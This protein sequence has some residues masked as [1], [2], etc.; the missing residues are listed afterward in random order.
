[1]NREVVEQ[2]LRLEGAAVTLA[3]DGAAA[4]E[5]LRRDPQ[6]YGLVLMDVQM[7]VMD[8]LTAARR[9]RCELGLNDLPLIAL[10]AGALPHER[11]AALAAGMNDVLTKP[12]RLEALVAMM[13]RYGKPRGQ[14][15]PQAEAFP[16]IPGIDREQATDILCGNRPLF[17]R[18]LGLFLA[19][20]DGL[21]RRVREALAQGHREKAALGLHKLKGNSGSLGA[22]AIMALAGSLEE[23]V[24]AGKS[25]LDLEPDL[26]E[27]DR[28]LQDLRQA[29]TPWLE[30]PGGA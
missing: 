14:D 23:A 13:L 10:T 16:A 30:D 1:M 15:G 2:A 8:G 18:L 6:A 28:Q 21:G 20:N 25:A 9:I 27:L 11:E 5:W 3:N 29:S 4:L 26:T 24:D 7:P 17:L 19:D 12:V 22:M